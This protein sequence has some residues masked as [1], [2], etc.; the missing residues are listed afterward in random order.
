MLRIVFTW[1][2]DIVDTVRHLAIPQMIALGFLSVMFGMQWLLMGE[3]WFGD[4]DQ[5]AWTALRHQWLP[6]IPDIMESG[7]LGNFMAG[8]F[9]V[10]VALVILGLPVGLLLFATSTPEW[11]RKFVAEAKEQCLSFH[12]RNALYSMA[13]S[14]LNGDGGPV[15]ATT[16]LFLSARNF[17]VVGMTRYVTPFILALNSVFGT[18]VM[19][20]LGLIASAY[21]FWI[22]PRVYQVFTGTYDYSKTGGTQDSGAFFVIALLFICP[23]ALGSLFGLLYGAINSLVMGIG[24][25]SWLWSFVP[26]RRLARRAYRHRASSESPLEAQKTDEGGTSA[27]EVRAF[28]PATAAPKKVSLAREVNQWK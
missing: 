26:G 14:S 3:G 13:L 21:A 22:V 24:L 4:Y 16:L 23:L 18:V 6:F 5:T 19:S 20:M 28:Y 15:S 11:H 2:G 25:G 27:R 1:L 8:W 12:L 7:S 10:I 9:L 17:L